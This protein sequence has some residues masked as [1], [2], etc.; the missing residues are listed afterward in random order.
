[1]GLLGLLALRTFVMRPYKVETGSMEPTIH[2]D[3][4]RVLVR[5]GS[6]EQFARFDMVVV[7]RG[8]GG[9]PLVKRLGGLPG[10]RIQLVDGDLF[11]G[12]QRA[13]RLAGEAP[14]ILLFG[15]PEQSIPEAF[16][17]RAAPETGPTA[18]Y[19]WVA[20]KDS[21]S[22]DS[23]EM[24]LAALDLAPGRDAGLL[25]FSAELRDSYF[26]GDGEWFQ[27]R[28]EVNDAG[29]EFE[30][31]VSETR[32]GARV[33]AR[34]VEEGDTF[35][36][37]LEINA[38][39]DGY[40]LRIERNSGEVLGANEL[41]HVGAVPLPGDLEP[42]QW[43]GFSFM[44]RD[45]RLIAEIGLLDGAGNALGRVVA[46]YEMNNA[47]LG[48]GGSP[49]AVPMRSVASRVA[50]GGE[51]VGM[52]LR[53]VRVTRDLFWIP[54]GDYAV[55]APFVLGPDEYFVLGDNSGKSSDSRIWGP[56]LGEGIIGGPVR[57]VWPLGRARKLK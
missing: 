57:V 41:P 49:S 19:P 33:R 40:S 23:A 30:F 37:I 3:G 48:T 7:D 25:R 56:V 43:L 29:V 53:R 9:A 22:S 52:E 16:A 14:Q 4:E 31:R 46:D 17:H 18:D 38:A 20:N 21:S 26:G 47:Y 6:H 45:N 28:H 24:T 2:G 54:L 42:G 10:E 39:G 36:A 13:G 5:F 27:G 44:N 15:S 34:L 12:G 1:M 11:V 32:A 50:L 51:A 8:E 55:D 35:E